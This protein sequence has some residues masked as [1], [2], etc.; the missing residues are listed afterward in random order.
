MRSAWWIIVLLLV[1]VPA[2]SALAIGRR[3]PPPVPNR[4]YQN[5][6]TAK[7]VY[8]RYYG[9]IHA[10]QIQNIGV[11]PGDVGLR[12]NGFLLNPW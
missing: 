7:V 12:G 11:P 1:I 8:P 4:Y 2:T 9:S 3:P 10:R 5:A 6:A